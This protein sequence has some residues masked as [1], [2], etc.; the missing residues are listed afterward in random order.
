MS[1][2][3]KLK[4]SP[5]LLHL[6][7]FTLNQLC[8]ELH[9]CKSRGRIQP[10]PSCL[11]LT[12]RMCSDD[13]LVPAFARRQFI[14]H[15]QYSPKTTN[16]KQRGG[17]VHLATLFARHPSAVDSAGLLS[18]QQGS[19]ERQERREAKFNTCTPPVELY[20][21]RLASKQTFTGTCRCRREATEDLHSCP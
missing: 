7:L 16:F 3:S 1:Y 11:F 14:L 15:R 4:P 6:H 17:T 5:A 18:I 8:A 9:C 10:S 13:T 2:Y 19:Q 12:F 21:G 20:F